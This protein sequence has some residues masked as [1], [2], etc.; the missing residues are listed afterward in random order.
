MLQ[1]IH[2]TT[3]ERSLGV[4]RVADFRRDKALVSCYCIETVGVVIAA[5]ER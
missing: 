4:V 5:L 1:V 2:I 3:V